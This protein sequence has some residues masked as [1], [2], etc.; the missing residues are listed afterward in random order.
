MDTVYK[1]CVGKVKPL[2]LPKK[3][4][5]SSILGHSFEAN[6]SLYKKTTPKTGL[7]YAFSD[8][9]NAMKWLEGFVKT[10]EF[11]EN[12]ERL[13]K[14]KWDIFILSGQTSRI[15]CKFHP[16]IRHLPTSQL[17]KDEMV[18][19]FW[20]SDHTKLS[21]QLSLLPEPKGSVLVP[22]FTPT[23]VSSTIKFSKKN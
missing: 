14:N 8:E 23:K 18:S 1:I 4:C 16:T 6:Y 21:K 22:D 12:I 17:I 13:K 3:S 9:E 7:L 2:K 19:E 5:F 15:A 11:K 10:D 20:K